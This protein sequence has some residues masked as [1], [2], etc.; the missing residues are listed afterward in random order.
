LIGALTAAWLLLHLLPLIAARV[1][2]A[3]GHRDVFAP[4]GLLTAL[5]LM[6]LPYLLLLSWD[7]SYL[8]V[9]MQSSH[10]VRDLP[11]AVAGYVALAS[12]GFLVMAA[13]LFSPLAGVFA[14]ALP[15]LPASRFTAARV[16]R[17]LVISGGVGALA[18]LYFLSRIGGLRSLWAVLY[19]RTLITAGM[20]YLSFAY[21]L[22]LTF[23]A[24]LLVYSLRFRPTLGRRLAIGAGIVAVGAVLASTGGR[25]GTVVLV[26]YSFMVAHYGVRRFRRLLTPATALVG[27]FLA[28]FILVMPLFRTAGAFEKYSDHPSLVAR[29]AF[30][31]L[32]RMAPDISGVDRGLLIVSYFTP[33]R[34]WLGAS[35]RDLL[36]APIPRTMYPEKPP[37]D[38]GVYLRAL[39]E[40]SEVRPSMPA[41][42]LPVTSWPPGN[43]I[44]Y[45]NFWLPGYLLGMFVVGAAIGAAYRYMARSG[46][47]PYSVYLYGF[48]IMGGVSVSN[49]S[50]V[51]LLMTVG[52]ASAFF[53]PLFGRFGFV[54]LFGRPAPSPAGAVPA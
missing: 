34:V 9:E 26:L 40:G 54:R 39:L 5:N 8:A 11:A 17:A 20:G 33:R 1:L 35:Y 43:L 27:V 47:T 2:R 15:V 7:V 18:Y 21:I 28:A 12:A 24:L 53:W 23:A 4:I 19:N 49:Y 30:R 32:A 52:I 36:L 51:S 10:W 45:M 41:G 16:R 14:R 22:L 44:L 3:R 38:D 37:V 50:I 6:N 25:S 46:Y 29:D 31:N 13:G 42:R 48:A